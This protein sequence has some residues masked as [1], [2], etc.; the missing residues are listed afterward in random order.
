MQFNKTGYLSLNQVK[1]D[2]RKDKNSLKQNIS[3]R[4]NEPEKNY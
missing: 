1:E 3:F 4:G 2:F